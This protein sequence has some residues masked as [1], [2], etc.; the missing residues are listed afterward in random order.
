MLINAGVRR[1]VYIGEYPDDFTQQILREAGIEL[2][3][4][5]EDLVPESEAVVR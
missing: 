2:V 1:V 5:T 4:Y 3:R